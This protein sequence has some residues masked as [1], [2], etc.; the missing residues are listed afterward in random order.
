MKLILKDK[1]NIYL[2]SD[3]AL[4]LEVGLDLLY[5]SFYTLVIKKVI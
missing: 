2:K 4:Y 1:L 3:F 5:T